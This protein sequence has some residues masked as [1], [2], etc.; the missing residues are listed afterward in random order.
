MTSTLIQ[1][2]KHQDRRLEKAF[3]KIKIQNFFFISILA[4]IIKALKINRTQ[5]ISLNQNGLLNL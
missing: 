4:S 5:S 1:R 3:K 2:N